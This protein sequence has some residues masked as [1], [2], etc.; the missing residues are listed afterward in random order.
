MP[1]AVI[2]PRRAVRAGIRVHVVV[3]VD[4]MVRVDIVVR[5]GPRMPIACNAKNT[6]HRPSITR[7]GRFHQ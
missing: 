7:N 1:R 4:V 2:P 6:A 3:D 5:V